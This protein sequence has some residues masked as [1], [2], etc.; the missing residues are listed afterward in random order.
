MGLMTA[1]WYF[2]KE[3]SVIFNFFFFFF[4]LRRGKWTTYIINKIFLLYKEEGL[5]SCFWCILNT[6]IHC[7]DQDERRNIILQHFSS[8]AMKSKGLLNPP[9]PFMYWLYFLFWDVFMAQAFTEPSTFFPFVESKEA[10]PINFIISSSSSVLLLTQLSHILCSL[11]SLS[12]ISS[13]SREGE[14]DVDLCRLGDLERLLWGER[15]WLPLRSPSL[16]WD[17]SWCLCS[18]SWDVDLTAYAPCDPFG[19]LLQDRE[20][21]I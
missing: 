11:F 8:H 4:F 17:L 19:I 12:S 18:L 3:K 15:E 16:D 20:I 14:G 1:K 9:F 13:F 6:K 5:W 2:L 10:N 21:S 7:S